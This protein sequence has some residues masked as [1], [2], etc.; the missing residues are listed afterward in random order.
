M[1]IKNNINE[2]VIDEVIK[3]L[4]EIKKEKMSI[5][6]NPPHIEGIYGLSDGTVY[7]KM[8]MDIHIEF[9]DLYKKAK[10]IITSWEKI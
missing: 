3:Y 9:N 10:D 5:T 4:T 1:N 2:N 6:I 7:G 8:E